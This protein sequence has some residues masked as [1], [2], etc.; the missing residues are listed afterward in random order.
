MKEK[1][2]L[3]TTKRFSRKGM[4]TIIILIALSTGVSTWLRSGF[5]FSSGIKT[6]EKGCTCIEVKEN[7]DWNILQ[8]MPFPLLPALDVAYSE[9][10]SSSEKQILLCAASP[11][12]STTCD[13]IN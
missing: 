5:T 13:S 1:I 2:N 4:I 3:T 8:A 6:D 10:L 11:V 12:K 7:E 9:Q